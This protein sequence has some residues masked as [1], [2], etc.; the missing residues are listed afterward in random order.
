MP[1]PPFRRYLSISSAAP[2]VPSDLSGLIIDFDGDKGITLDGSS[3]V[4]GWANQGSTGSAQNAFMSTIGNR[5]GYIASNSSYNNHGT[6]T[7]TDTGTKYLQVTP[8][9]APTAAEIFIVGNAGADPAPATGARAANFRFGSDCYFPFS[10]S[11]VYCTTFSVSGYR[12][13]GNPT[14]S[15]ATPWLFNVA[16]NS[17]SWVGKL[18]TATLASVGAHTFTFGSGAGAWLLGRTATSFFYGNFARIL[19]YN[20]ILTSTERAQVEQ[21]CKTTYG[22]TGY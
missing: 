12:Y 14:P 22:L 4:S 9:T 19:I 8:P 10:D 18:N 11:I 5:P 7:N 16:A 3:N 20:R 15:L 1:V 2:F 21:Y 6:I 13:N 17:S